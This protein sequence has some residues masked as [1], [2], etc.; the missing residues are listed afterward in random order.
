MD[1]EW[2]RGTHPGMPIN[3]TTTTTFAE[4]ELEDGDVCGGGE[5]RDDP[6]PAPEDIIISSS[7]M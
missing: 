7:Y 3:R 5:R 1:F 6:D 4:V 2:G